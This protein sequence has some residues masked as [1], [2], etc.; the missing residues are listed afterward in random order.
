MCELED[1]KKPVV[2]EVRG[3]DE[4]FHDCYFITLDFFGISDLYT[5]R[6]LVNISSVI[7]EN[8]SALDPVHVSRSY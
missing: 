7:G 8:E 6:N 2:V 4:A 3:V 5:L 1:G